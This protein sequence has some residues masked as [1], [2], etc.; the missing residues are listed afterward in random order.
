MSTLLGR[1]RTQV[2]QVYLIIVNFGVLIHYILIIMRQSV[3]DKLILR[4]IGTVVLVYVWINPLIV[5]VPAVY[6]V[7]AEFY[8]YKLPHCL[9]QFDN[10]IF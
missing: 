6:P 9:N 7:T 5:P 2:A 10:P 1:T 3:C 8:D 4:P